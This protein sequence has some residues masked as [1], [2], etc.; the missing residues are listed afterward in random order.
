MSYTATGHSE[1]KVTDENRIF[2]LN[3]YLT[4]DVE[5]LRQQETR[6]EKIFT[7]VFAV[8]FAAKKRPILKR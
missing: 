6:E 7:S 2:R 5:I 4:R 1:N 8:Q 3:T